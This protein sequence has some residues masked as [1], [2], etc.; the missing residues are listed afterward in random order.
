[1]LRE[2]KLLLTAKLFYS[3]HVLEEM[4]ER[5]RIGIFFGFWKKKNLLNQTTIR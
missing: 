1:M 3:V 2:K 5:I 4:P